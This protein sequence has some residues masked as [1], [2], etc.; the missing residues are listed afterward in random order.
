MHLMMWCWAAFLIYRRGCCWRH[1]CCAGC[2]ASSS[3]SEVTSCLQQPCVSMT[4]SWP[5]GGGSSGTSLSPARCLWIL[6]SYY[7]GFYHR[8]CCAF[9]LFIWQKVSELGI[10][11]SPAV[12]LANQCWHFTDLSLLLNSCQKTTISRK[13][14]VKHAL[15]SELSWNDQLAIECKL[16]CVHVIVSLSVVLGWNCFFGAC[17]LQY[18]RRGFPLSFLP[19]SPSV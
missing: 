11:L 2:S 3:G 18:K 19:L 8:S 9:S 10:S 14:N 7:L 17:K 13:E 6:V 4:A 1:C 5:D 16:C 12:N 15:L